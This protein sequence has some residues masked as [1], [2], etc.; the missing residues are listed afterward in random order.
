MNLVQGSQF[1]GHARAVMLQGIAVGGFN[2]VDIHALAAMLELP[3][4][5]VMRREPDLDSI[6]RALLGDK[7]RSAPRV[8]GAAR[9]WRLIEQAGPIERL[10]IARS[11]AACPSGLGN[12]PQSIWVQRA[13]ISLDAA[14]RMVASTTLHGHV[15]EPLR[16]AHLVAGG[17]ATGRSRGRV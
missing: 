15:P 6:R 2:V 1:R 3:V 5:V 13:D 12:R 9:K 4:L 8:P 10:D 11:D 14:S 16:L 17:V 7:P